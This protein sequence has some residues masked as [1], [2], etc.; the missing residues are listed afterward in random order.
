ML[1]QRLTKDRGVTYSNL[2]TVVVCAGYGDIGD[3]WRE[4]L[5]IPDIGEKI[6]ELHG[7]ILPFYRLLHG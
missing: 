3:A 7:A 6:A 2:V 4:Q 1:A 5:D